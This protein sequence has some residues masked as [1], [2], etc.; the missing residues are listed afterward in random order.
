MVPFN[1][2][3]PRKILQ[4]I[5]GRLATALSHMQPIHFTP[6]LP[7]LQGFDRPEPSGVQRL[8]REMNCKHVLLELITKSPLVK[9]LMYMTNIFSVGTWAAA[10]L[11]GYGRAVKPSIIEWG[12][13]LLLFKRA[14]DKQ[15]IFVI[16]SFRIFVFSYLSQPCSLFWLT[17]VSTVAGTNCSEKERHI[18]QLSQADAFENSRRWKLSVIPP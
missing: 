9:F 12:V 8:G 13:S 17:E 4:Q 14:T 15:I 16:R 6:G 3:L 7:V 10:E 1:R 2:V 5:C 18:S 11:T